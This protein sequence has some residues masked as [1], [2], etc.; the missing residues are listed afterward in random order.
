MR[1][2][3][4]HIVMESIPVLILSSLIAIGAGLVLSRSILLIPGIIVMI[5]AFIN[6]SGSLMSVLASR[7]SSALHMGLIHPRLHRTKTLDRNILAVFI[8]SV[9]SFLFLGFAGGFLMIFLGLGQINILLM[10]F[11]ILLAGLITTAILVFFT[12]IMSYYLYK[13]GD[14]PDNWVIPI[15]TSSS[16]FIGIVLLIFFVGLII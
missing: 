3:F 8:I 10:S 6:M 14:D 9:I 16:D 1:Y 12:V 5:P 2:T 13:K 15:L 11:M 7:L 4:K